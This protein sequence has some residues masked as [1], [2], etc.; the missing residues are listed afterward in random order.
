M[1]STKNAKNL[2]YYMTL[3]YKIEFIPN[4]EEGFTTVI[5][6]LKGCIS[7]GDS[8]QEAYEM[9]TEAK[10]LWIETALDKGWDVPKPED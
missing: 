3:P 7:F 2:D 6:R 5:P 10:Q 8:L 1:T 4:E 9:I